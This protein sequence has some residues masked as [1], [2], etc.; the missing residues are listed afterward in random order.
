MVTI[1]NPVKTKDM[2]TKLK[3]A[4]SS[5]GYYI[6]LYHVLLTLVFFF[7]CVNA[8]AQSAATSGKT[9]VKKPGKPPLNMNEYRKSPKYAARKAKLGSSAPGPTTKTVP[10]QDGTKLT[11]TL[12]TKAPTSGVTGPVTKKVGKEKKESSG[13]YDCTT[14]TVNLTA[15]STNFLNNDYAGTT[16]NIYPGACYTYA[17][18]TNGSW[19]ETTGARNS[20]QITTDNPNVRDSSY[21][22]VQNPNVGTL[23][24]A[25]AK[26]Y[27][28]L[29]KGGGEESLT[30]QVSEATNSAV[31][32]LQIGAA[33]S[34]FGVDLSN[35]Y[36]TGNQS[37]HVHVTID[38]TKVLFSISTSPPDSGFFKDPKIEATPYLSYIS[39]VNYGVRVLAN[40]DITFASQEEADQFK[41]SYSG[42]GVSVSLNVDYGTSSKNT[43]ATI[44]GYMIG[45]PGNQLVAYSLAD[46]KKQIEKAFAGATFQNARPISY[47]VC[48]MAGDQINTYSATD[49][50]NVRNCIPAAAGPPE[51]DNITLTFTQGSQGRSGNTFYTVALMPGMNQETDLNKAMFIYNSGPVATQGYAA[52]SNV[53]IVLKPNKPVLDKQGKILGGYKGKFTLDEFQKSGGHVLIC[54]LAYLPGKYQGDSNW[55]VD[56]VAVKINLKPTAADPNPP[57]PGGNSLSWTLTGPNEVSLWTSA[58]AP[59][60]NYSYLFFDQNFNPQGHQ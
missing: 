40:A 51:I 14:T 12:D 53:T 39:N 45:G 4:T 17:N 30:Y 31:Y 48:D 24:T 58:F 8:L 26:L 9:T 7:F 23:Q 38:A 19:K 35:V 28:R 2:K 57:T 29:P 13:G 60:P 22:N 56:G 42:F 52:N 44:N 34:G 59:H 43:T 3:H 18:L 10:F 6:K 41:G 15:T 1:L 54:P 27:S 33:A 32:N 20:L 36:S 46:L 50:F 25:V 21:Q 5:E 11:I 16:A 55:T 37:N 47:E 49:N